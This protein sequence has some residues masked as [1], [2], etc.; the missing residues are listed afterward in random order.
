MNFRNIF[1]LL[2]FATGVQTV[3]GQA[4][5]VNLSSAESGTQTHQ[6]RNS[7][8]LLAGYSYTPGGDGMLAEI[9]NPV[10]T[11]STWYN[12]SPVDPA[13]R[14][15]STSCL[16]GATQGNFNVNPAGGASY[17]IP[18]DVLPGVNGLAPSLSLVYSSNSGSGVA[19]YG[20]QIGGISVVSRAGQNYY[21]DGAVRGIELDYNDRYLIDGQ[22][23]VLAPSTGSWGGHLTTY[24]TET[25]IF[26]R[27]QSQYS[28]GNGPQKFMAQTKSGLK[29]LY[30]FTNDGCQKIDGYSEIINWFVTETQDLYG[31][32]ISYAYVKDNNTVYPAEITYGLNKVTF[33]YKERTDVTTSYLKGTKIQQRLLLDKITVTYN[34][35][36]VKTYELRYN[37]INDN[38]NSY[39]ALNEVTEYGT[40]GSRLNSTVFSYSIP[41][42]VAFT[43][44]LY[45]T[46]HN[47]VTYKSKLVTGDYNGD[48][49]A[50]FLCI[51]VPNLA[52]WTGIEV[53]YGDGNDNFNYGFS[54]TTSLDLNNLRDVRSLDVNGDGYED[55]L[56]EMISSGTSTFYYMLFNGSSFNPPVVI[57]TL[58]TDDKTG[59]SGKYNRVVEYQENDN[60]NSITGADYNGDGINDILVTSTSGYYQIFTL[61]N[62]SGQLGTSLRNVTSSNSSFFKE[63]V[64]TADFNGNGKSDV[65]CTTSSGT[66]IFELDNTNRMAI[67]YQSSWPKSTHHFTLGDFNADGKTDVFVYGYTTYDWSDWQVC[68]STGTGFTTNYIPKKKSN[69]KDDYVRLGDFNGD[70]ATDLMVSSS[71][72]SWSGTKFYITKNAGTDFYTNSL[73]SYPPSEHKYNVADFNGDGRTDFLCTDGVSPYWNGYQIY[74]SGSKSRILLE[75]IGNG[76]NDLTKITYQSISEYGTTYVKGTGASF[77]VMDFQGPLQV[78]K[79]VLSDNGLGSQNTTNCKFEGA[80]IHRQGKGF[81]CYS[82]TAVTDATAGIVNETLSD[83]NTV[84]FYP[85]VTNVIKKTAGGA[86]IESTSNIWTQTVLDSSTKRIFPYISSSTQTNSLTG[87]S[88]TF[89]STCDSYGNPTQLVKTYSNGVS[90]TTVSNYTNTVN[91]TDWKLGRL[92]NST[93]TYAKSGETSVSHAVRYTYFTDGIMKPDFIYYN[94]GTAL[95][96]FKNHD[97]NAQGNLIQVHTYGASIGA[98]QVNYTYD[99]D[100]IRVKTKTDELGHTTTFNYNSYGQLQ[101]EVDYLNNTNT[102]AYD[103]LGRQTSVSNTN[104]SQTTT[105][106]VWTGTNKPSLG[107]YGVTQTGNDGSVVTTWYDK[108][109]R[110]IRTEKKGFG[111]SMIFIDTEYNAKGQVYRVS[112]PYFAGGSQVWAETY[113]YDGYGRTTNISRNTGR[114]TIYSYNSSTISETTGGKT[115]SKTY[116]SDGSLTSA[117][118]NGGTITYAYYPDGKTKSITAPGGVVTT[119]QYGD[120]ARNQTQLADPSAGTIKYTYNSL[121]QIKTQ[122]D[123]RN[124]VTTYNYLDDGRTSNIETPEGTTTYAYNTNK[125]LTGI[126]NSA[127]N[128]SRSYGYDTKGRVNSIGESI[129]GTN[130]STSFTY[131]TKGRLDTRT[132][133]SGIVETMGYNSYG[134]LSTISA[135][136]STRY[137]ITSMNAREQLTGS[138]Y[139]SNLTADYGIDD[140]G[141]PKWTKAGTVQDYRYSFDP[142]TGNLNS[143]QNFIHSLSE[144]FSYTDNGDNLDRLTSVAGPQNLNMKYAANGNILTKSDINSTVDFGYGTNAGPYALTEVSSPTGVIPEV[145]QNITYTSFEKVATIAEG[146]YNAAFVYNG[147][148]QRARMAITQSGNTIL[149]RWYAGSSYM[150]ETAG[151]VTKEYTYI[152]GDAYT[153]PVAAVTQSGTT[154]YYYLLRDY[155]GNITHQ[156]NASN[157]IVAEYNFDAWGRRR[158]A[159]DWSYTLD[160]NDQALFA[161]RGFTA[162]EHL[163]WFNLVNMNGRLYDPLVGRFLSADPYV[164]MPDGT[165][166][167]NRYSYCLNNPLKYTDPDGELPFLA[168]LGIVLAGN[169]VIGWLDNVINKHMS[170]KEAF[171]NTNFI[172]GLNFSPGDMSKQNNYGVSNPQVDAQKL[173]EQQEEAQKKVNK[174]IAKG[175]A[176][177][178]LGGDPTKSFKDTKG[179]FLQ[180]GIK[181]ETYT[182][183]TISKGTSPYEIV[184][185]IKGVESVN[186]NSPVGTISMGA[187]GSYTYGNPVLS[188]G[189]DKFGN[190]IIDVNIPLPRGKFDNV[191]GTLYLSKQPLTN[192]R[193]AF[194][195]SLDNSS[196]FFSPTRVLPNP[197]YYYYVF[198][199]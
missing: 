54:E 130:F 129:A 20:W 8:S 139:G 181:L 46:S 104:G 7:I 193:D 153:A 105:G 41:D 185:N 65:W 197:Y 96:F 76:L 61:A 83:F 42:E 173:A 107:L 77:P 164:Q 47:Y 117:T 18:I 156:V 72:Q 119:M 91:S 26:T 133:P 195:N 179:F 39:S 189:F 90:E 89:S 85:Q 66:T 75:K 151:G 187:D 55:V 73:P 25:D 100:Q 137:T 1:I 102:F 178:N 99:T 199:Y 95:E 172:I 158:S 174:A 24:Q 177:A 171:K 132:H 154:T 43:Q 82:K 103:A 149:T 123:A 136:G 125:Q 182:I 108:L 161:D 168:A 34:S 111:G 57:T 63:R 59:L 196:R 170:A 2:L 97:Y 30:G 22:R 135:G 70:G 120:A 94:E 12:Y 9:V 192:L 186:Y 6:A 74:R 113:T 180:G 40:G 124:Q 68:L 131:D 37:Q 145:A 13:N 176:R 175:R 80:K 147:D 110:A 88:V 23:L 33:Y 128:V 191:G 86:S 69:L 127:T 118:D 109:Q 60:E 98:S 146:D 122:T 169:Y 162:H 71:N 19:G 141:Y 28:S 56:Y 140:Y 50:D 15:L 27:V 165:Q 78:V 112:D 31:N 45:N 163:P 11:G 44:K 159:D 198:T 157:V 52:S 51:P 148:N 114:N 81:L 32:I 115:F 126:S 67:V 160:G 64:L 188:T 3:L 79:S 142:V 183:K 58:T 84:Y 143:R 92:D 87:H 17:T 49:K 106:Y 152:G 53:Y 35:T 10:I 155:L 150:K 16:V 62:T 144:S 48:G 116:G 121:G 190:L 138:T 5:D 29:N 93:V 36:E 134:Y 167:Y 38:Y 4:F 184:T 14:T 194:F 166:S 21:N 101:T